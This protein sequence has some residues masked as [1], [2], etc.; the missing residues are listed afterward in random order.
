MGR[1]RSTNEETRILQ[2]TV[3]AAH[4]ATKDLNAAIKV[5]L[6]LAPTLISEFEAVHQRET[7]LLVAF[8]EKQADDLASTLNI[9]VTNAREEILRQLSISEMVVDKETGALRIRFNG[10]RFT[11]SNKVQLTKHNTEEFTP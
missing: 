5:A 7:K 3:R 9:D 4:E 2:D 6:A 11:T 8:L 1:T 10:T